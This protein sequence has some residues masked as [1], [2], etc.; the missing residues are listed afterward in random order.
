MAP[1]KSRRPG[2]SRK[3]QYGLFFGYAV[4]IVGV[5]AALGLLVVERVY[6]NALNGLRGLAL[7]VTSPVTSSGRAG[8]RAVGEGG[9][10]VGDYFRAGATNA[11]LREQIKAMRAQIL[12]ARATEFENRRLKALLGLREEAEDEI[13]IARIVSSSF[14]SSRRLATLSAGTSQGVRIGQPVRAPEGLVGRIVETGRWASRVLLVTDGASNVPVQS[15][16]TGIP[17]MATGRG[18]GTIDIKPL[19]VGQNPFRRGDLFITSGVGGIYAPGIPVAMVVRI[20]GDETLAR[21]IADPAKLD[22]A[23]VQSIFQPAANQPLA[24]ATPAAPTLPAAPPAPAPTP[25][26]AENRQ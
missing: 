12:K 14:D 23:I 26:A 8:V 7:D 22:Y 3:A 4:A 17:A 13:A 20:N 18:D 2:F 1:P 15:L 16:R 19:E 10:A 24:A 25:P 11:E 9:A 21:P 5:L 6:P